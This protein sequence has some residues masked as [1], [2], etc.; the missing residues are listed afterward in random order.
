[1]AWVKVIGYWGKEWYAEK[2]GNSTKMSGK[3]C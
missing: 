2:G 1:M 3:N